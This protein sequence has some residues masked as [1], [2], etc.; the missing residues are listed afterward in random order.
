MKLYRRVGKL[1]PTD[2]P[3]EFN[4]TQ[5]PRIRVAVSPTG[6][7]G[8]LVA[9]AVV[10]VAA[11]VMVLVA[12]VVA[13]VD[14]PTDAPIVLPFA[15][16]V[17]HTPKLFSTA[18]RPTAAGGQAVVVATELVVDALVVAGAVV[19]TPT[20]APIVFPF[21]STVTHTP[22]LFSTAVR[23]TGAAGQPVVVAADVV[24]DEVVVAKVTPALAPSVFPLASSVTQTPSGSRDTVN[25]TAA[26]GQLTLGA[27]VVVATALL[28][29]VL[30]N[31]TPA[32][33]PNVFPLASNVTQTPTGLR[34]TVNPT[35]AAG[36]LTTGLEV[37]VD[38][39]DVEVEV[40]VTPALAPTVPPVASKVTQ[41]PTGLRDTVRPTAAGGQLTL[42]VEEVVAEVVVGVRV[43]P[44]L[45][46]I[47]FPDASTVT[48]TPKS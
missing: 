20:D 11:E 39:L 23:P 7:L 5:T 48:Q 8:Q 47:V 24:A 19:D 29:E 33:A 18:V 27:E 44:A 13:V 26:A 3:F 36:Q 9:T 42:G 32:L 25:P 17:T 40:N 35:A 10:V 34:D 22:K 4:V 15:S 1:A 38:A 37:V 30:V 31:V 12:V 45:A 41:I 16:T 14:T 28:V 43:T 6:A 46:P 21:A 2:T